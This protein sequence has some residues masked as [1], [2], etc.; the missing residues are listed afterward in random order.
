MDVFEL[1]DLTR[2]IQ[3]NHGPC[4]TIMM[5]THLS[6]PDQEQDALR[7]KNLADQAQESL[8]KGWLRPCQAR[9]WLEP[10]RQSMEDVDF[11]EKRNLGLALFLKS[12]SFE[13]FRLPIPLE[14]LVL[15]NQRFYLKPLIR[16][17]T[18][19]HRFLLL[20]VSQNHVALFEA[21]E[22]QIQRVHV[23]GLP[24]RIEQTLNIDEVDRGQQRHMSN[25]WSK[26]KQPSVFHGHGGVK[27]THKTEL[28]LFFN[29]IDEVLAP[30]LRH[31]TWPMVL[32]GVD[33][34]LPILRKSLRYPNVVDVEIHGNWDYSMNSQL[35][36]RA[37]PIV[38]PWLL[39]DQNNAREKFHDLSNTD[40]ATSD[41]QTAIK[42]A[43][44]GRVD[45][46]FV[47]QEEH[48]WGRCDPYGQVSAT[49]FQIQSG[50]DDLLD[51]AAAQTI[52]HGGKVY[53]MNKDAMPSSASIAAVLRF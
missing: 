39:K 48:L 31:H 9:E 12:D 28:T 4:V 35:L 10:V 20:C 43:F 42:A 38:Q 40:L 30:T 7:L 46:L 32:A 49:H 2:L 36:E 14:E 23:A 25:R 52:L 15:V 33:Y 26:G 18:G 47:N 37:W 13:R 21:S 16:L 27:D 34:L 44:D 50:D 5:P 11:W 19:N 17:V 1:S 6:G 8:S 24:Q 29:Q 3:S 41:P 51:T 53:A 45:T 22:F